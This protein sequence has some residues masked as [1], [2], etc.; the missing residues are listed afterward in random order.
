M[1]IRKTALCSPK[2]DGQCQ[3]TLQH[4]EPYLSKHTLNICSIQYVPAETFTE[5]EI[6]GMRQLLTVEHCLALTFRNA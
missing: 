5:G 3:P 4:Y 1:N 6:P 2:L